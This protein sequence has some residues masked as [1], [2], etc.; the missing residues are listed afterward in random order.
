MLPEDKL[1]EVIKASAKDLGLDVV[2]RKDLEKI[3]EIIEE[4]FTAGRDNIYIERINDI[5]NKYLEIE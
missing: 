3:Q 1:K 2:D 4:F 5:V